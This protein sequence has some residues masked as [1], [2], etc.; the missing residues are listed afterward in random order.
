MRVRWLGVVAMRA[1]ASER[2]REREIGW[3]R[4]GVVVVGAAAERGMMRRLP[5]L[6]QTWEEIVS[7]S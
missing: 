1:R 3:V 7:I 4:E 6:I 2:V 5:E